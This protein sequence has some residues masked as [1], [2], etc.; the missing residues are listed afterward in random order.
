VT[1]TT[2]VRLYRIAQIIAAGLILTTVAG[3]ATGWLTWE[4]FLNGF[5]ALIP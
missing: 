3:V 5:L 2:L 4:S 1:E